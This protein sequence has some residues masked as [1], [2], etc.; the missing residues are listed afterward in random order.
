MKTKQ[1]FVEQVL[2]KRPHLPTEEFVAILAAPIRRSV[3]AD[4]RIRHWGQVTDPR[5]GQPRVLRIVTLD[6]GETIHN[7]FFDR[8]Y[9]EDTP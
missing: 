6:D 3:Q 1:Y 8:G 7:A 9:R 2:R 4:G 5:N